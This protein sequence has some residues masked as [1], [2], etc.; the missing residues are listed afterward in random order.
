MQRLKFLIIHK[1]TLQV[2]P[3]LRKYNKAAKLPELTQV[4]Q[5]LSNYC[6]KI[7]NSFTLIISQIRHNVK[8]G[9]Y[10]ELNDKDVTFFESLI[11]NGNVLKAGEDDLQGYNVD[12][13]RSVRGSSELVLKPGSTQEISE[14]LQHCNDRRL[15]VCPQGGNTGLVGGSVPVCDEIVLSLSRLNKV[16]HIDDITG[17]T[18]CESGCILENLDAKTREAGLVVPIDLGAKSSCHIGGNI[19]T[20]AGGLRVIRYGNLHGSVLG[21]EAVSSF[22][23]YKCCIKVFVPNLAK[24]LANGKVLDLMSDFKK[25]NTGYHLKHLFIGS[26]GTLGVVTKLALLCPPIPES[27]NLSFLGRGFIK[28]ST[29]ILTSQ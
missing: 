21:V 29:Y 16:L 25:D 6:A 26:E 13:L 24:V 23:F 10:A 18:A 2:S 28:A 4:K 22:Y 1:N 9:N 17:I 20:N 12:F 11:G 15:A 14:I 7:R 5:Q 27:V 8:R 3:I 19:S